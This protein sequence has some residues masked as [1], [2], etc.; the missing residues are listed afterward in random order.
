MIYQ[1]FMKILGLPVY[2][3]DTQVLIIKL[4]SFN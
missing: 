2:S 1:M 3:N 4:N